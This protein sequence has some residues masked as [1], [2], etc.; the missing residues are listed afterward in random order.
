M[1]RNV[2]YNFNKNDKEH[3]ICDLALISLLG[4]YGKAKF[5]H[6]IHS[7]ACYRKHDNGVFSSKYFLEKEIFKVHIFTTLANYYKEEK[8]LND[9]FKDRIVWIKRNFKKGIFYSKE[10]S[11]FKKVRFFFKKIN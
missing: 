6:E 8:E 1:F 10:I 5:I 2:I 7:G 3:I 9:Y 11:F 4:K